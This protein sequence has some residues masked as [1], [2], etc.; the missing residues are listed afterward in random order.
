MSEL[1]SNRPSVAVAYHS[2]YGH[3]AVLAE[4]VHRGAAKTGADT[5][6]I[7]VTTITDED[8]HRLDT[9]DAIIFGSPTYMGGASAGFHTFAEATSK[10]FV[11]GR[12]ADKL[13]AGFT[14]SASKSGDKNNTLAFF[15]ALAAQHRMLWVSLGL[16]P[17]W[18][19]TT[20]SEH[21]LNRLGFWTGAA[22]QTPMDGGTDTVHTSDITTAEHLGTRVAH[23]AATFHA[24]R[25]ALTTTH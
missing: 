23:H 18:N 2:G 20:A 21:D 16:E 3:T 14:N 9:A 7:D 22:A 10:R 11:E 6:L 25:R 13:A 15:A 17:G 12:W 24:G 4:A 5:T 19:S 8:W 1:S